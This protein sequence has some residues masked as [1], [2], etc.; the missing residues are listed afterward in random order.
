MDDFLSVKNLSVSFDI[1][2]GLLMRK[3]ATVNAVNDVSFTLKRGETIGVVGESGCGKTTLAR[4]LMRL[5]APSSGSIFFKGEDLLALSKKEMKAKRSQLQMVFQDPYS[6]FD[7]RYTIYRSLNEPFRIR[8]IRHSRRERKETLDSLLKLVGLP[9]NIGNAYPHQ[10][11]GGQKQ[12]ADIAR[13]LALRPELLVLDEPTASLDVSV[14][15]QVVKLLEDL[16]EQL[17]L[18]YVF[19]S[20][21]LSLVSYFCDRIIVMYMGNVMEILDAEEVGARAAHPYTRALIANIP[22][23]RSDAGH[24]KLSLEGEPPSPLD[25]PRGCAF[26]GRCP[27]AKPVCQNEKPPIVDSA[28]G[29]KVACHFPLL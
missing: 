2:G 27:Y 22:R 7:P 29:G 15:A 21:D 14:Q 9:T 13:A 16:R 23:I 12:R 11:S 26:S 10:I 24:E 6:V 8:N 28:A 19:I 5:V 18:T 20:H 3:V 25:V 1:K 17:D 4:M